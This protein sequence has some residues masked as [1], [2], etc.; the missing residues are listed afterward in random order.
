MFVGSLLSGRAVDY[1][2][3]TTGT[4]VTKNWTGF[5]LASALAAFVIFLYVAIF[6]RSTGRVQSKESQVAIADA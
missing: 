1:F 3:T 6:F 2:T 5:W 4:T